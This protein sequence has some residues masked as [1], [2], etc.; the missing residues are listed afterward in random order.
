MKI[1]TKAQI[2]GKLQTYY[3]VNYGES[4]R[5][6]WYS[7]PAANVWMFRRDSKII[8]LQCHILT[9]FVTEQSTELPAGEPL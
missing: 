1:L 7:A 8:T 6:V 9:G 5:D 4:D 3:Q 2:Q